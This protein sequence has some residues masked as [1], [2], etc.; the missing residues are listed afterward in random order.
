MT[1]LHIN[2]PSHYDEFIDLNEQWISQHFSIEASDRALAANPG[3]VIDKGGYILS[4]TDKQQ[5][6]GVCALF[7]Q[8][9]GNFELARLAVG[10]QYRGQG[11]GDRLIREA[12]ALLDS[13]DAQTVNLMSNTKLTTALSLYRKHGFG[14]ISEG[15]HPVYAR[16]NIIME[17]QLR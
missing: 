2:N 7:N 4:L 17:K 5:V 11:H 9:E 13:L 6:I 8:G 1:E 14:V 10:E 3:V 15:P 12:L 16:T